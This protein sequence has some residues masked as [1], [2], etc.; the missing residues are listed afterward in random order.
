MEK[1]FGRDI[2]VLNDATRAGNKSVNELKG[3]LKEKLL[4]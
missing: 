1:V 4:K 2:G 3:E